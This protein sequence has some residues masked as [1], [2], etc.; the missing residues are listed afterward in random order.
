MATETADKICGT[1]PLICISVQ[2][3]GP[4]IQRS[5]EVTIPV[6]ATSTAPLYSP[7]LL[8]VV[9]HTEQLLRVPCVEAPVAFLGRPLFVLVN[10]SAYISM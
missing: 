2:E 3:N 8:F 9:G 7:G 1:R 10:Y 4:D 5:I 6:G